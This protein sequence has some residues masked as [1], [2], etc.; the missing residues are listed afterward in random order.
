MTTRRY[1]VYVENTFGFGRGPKGQRPTEKV[2]TWR[3]PSDRAVVERAV[4]R[5]GKMVINEYAYDE[6]GR[7]ELTAELYQTCRCCGSL[8]DGHLFVRFQ[9]R[10]AWDE[11]VIEAAGEWTD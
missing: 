4:T 7:I 5:F 8:I 3:A 11:D 1:E 2:E 10:D 9:A 6:E